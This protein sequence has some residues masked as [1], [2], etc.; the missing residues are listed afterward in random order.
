MNT[1][2]KLTI[3]LVFWILILGW[4]FKKSRGKILK[5][6]FAG[7]ILHALYPVIRGIFYN[8]Y[9]DWDRIEKETLVASFLPAL[10]YLY[11]D[12]TRWIGVD[13]ENL[14]TKVFSIFSELK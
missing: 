9:P 10:Y 7:L 11:D 5:A 2:K 14:K 6:V 12:I 13:G 3:S 4:L 8:G 1:E